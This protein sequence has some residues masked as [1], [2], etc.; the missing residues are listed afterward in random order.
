MRRGLVAVAVLLSASAAAAHSASDSH[1]RLRV[2]GASL[3]ARWDIAL[4]DLEQAIGLDAD[5]DGA[6]TWGEVR[7]RQ[8][9]IAAYALAR[10]QIA[11]DEGSCHH[12][13]AALRIA[14]HSDGGYAALAFAVA[15]PRPPRRLRLRYG[16]FFDFDPQHRGLVRI[17][18]LA[19]TAAAP[20]LAATALFTADRPA[21]DVPLD[22]GGAW[23][24]LVAFWRNGVWHIWSGYDHMLFLLALLLPAVLRRRDGVWQPIGL[25]AACTNTLK[26]VTAFTVAHSITLS[27]AAAG[28][29]QVPSRLVEAGIAASVVIAALNNAYPLFAESRWLVGFAFGLLHG[30]GFASVL[31][32]PDLPLRSLTTALGGFN[33]GV[34]S[35]QL[36]LVAGFLPLAY[37]ARR[38]WLYQRLTLIGGSALIAVVAGIWLVERVFDVKLAVV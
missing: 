25:R 24:S 14:R 21:Q 7:R 23:A 4:R 19:G 10:L 1:L 30:F 17:E 16:L 11:G 22:G 38:S 8:D 5:G 12:G 26:V 36:A 15:C 28:L 29:V 35:G 31:A 18:P 13:P 6:I 27:L 9:A 37:L 34:E 2:D 20:T 33:A 3:Q 32:A